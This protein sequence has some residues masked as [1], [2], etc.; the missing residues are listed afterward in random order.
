[1]IID[2]L[3]KE[4][5]DMALN[6]E[7]RI[8]FAVDYKVDTTSLQ[9]ARKSLQE[10]QK[11]SLETFNSIGNNRNAAN[12]ARQLSLLKQDALELEQALARSFNADLGV[13]NVQ[14]LR[15]ELSE[16]PM[17]EIGERFA[18]AGAA[19]QN[20]FNTIAGQALSLNNTLKQTGP[21]LTKIQQT[22]TNALS[23]NL[24]T[25][26]FNQITK[27]ISQAWGYSKNLDN[28]LNNIRI[29][30]RQSAEEMERFAQTAQ[31]TAKGLGQGTVDYT[32]AALIY[33]QQGLSDEEVAKKT[34]TTLKT[35]N[36]TGKSA[37][38]VSQL[39]T[40]VWN[41]YKVDAD[42]AE[43]YVDKLAAVASTTAADL[44]ELS[45]AMSKVASVAST[46][47]VDIDQLNAQISTI[48][49][50][51][52]QAP[53][54][55]GTALKTIYSRIGDLKVDGVDEF[56]V[57]LGKISSK[58]K[59]MGV[60][61]LDKNGDM[62]E[63][64]VVFEEVADKW[65]NWTSA[66]K[67]AA[68]VALGGS[69]QYTNLFALF[70]NW[71]DYESTLVTSSK[72]IGTLQE[73]Q[74]TYAERLTT[75]LQQ[76]R[77]AWEGVY[78]S[79]FDK[80]DA[81]KIVDKL[82]SI[83]ETIEKFFD[84]VGGGIPVIKLLGSMLL[85]TFSTKIASGFT[86][87]IE[88]S[89]ISLRNFTN[90]Q[91]R[92][93]RQVENMMRNLGVQNQNFSQYQITS[94]ADT[95]RMFRSR[96]SVMTEDELNRVNQS[97]ER[98]IQLE[99]QVNTHA[100]E[101]RKTRTFLQGLGMD[102][103][104]DYSL[105]QNLDLQRNQQTNQVYGQD[106]EKRQN[107]FNQIMS[108]RGSN[109]F[110]RVDL[111]FSR[112]FG[113]LQA[114]DQRMAQVVTDINQ[115][116]N[117]SFDSEDI[118]EIFQTQTR[119]GLQ[120][121]GQQLNTLGDN[122]QNINQRAQGAL[123][124]G[125]G[126]PEN[127][128]RG[129]VGQRD[130]GADAQVAHQQGEQYTQE[131]DILREAAR[132]QAPASAHSRA[133]ENLE[134]AQNQL[135]RLTTERA[136]AQ[137]LV[138]LYVEGARR[139]AQQTLETEL[140]ATADSARTRQ[141]N[142]LAEQVH[143]NTAVNTA[144][145]RV[146]V[147]RQDLSAAVATGDINAINQ[148]YTNLSNNQS[149][150][151]AA[152][153]ELTVAQQAYQRATQE[154]TEAVAAYNAAQQQD[155]TTLESHLAAM[156]SNS[157]AYREGRAEL[158]N[159]NAAMNHA[160]AEETAG[161]RAVSEE[162]DPAI[163]ATRSSITRLNTRM[164]ELRA[165]YEQLP[166]VM[167]RNIQGVSALDVALREQ[168]DAYQL[169]G[170]E[171]QGV[172][173]AYIQN[174]RDIAQNIEDQNVLQRKLVE[175]RQIFNQMRE[176]GLID[177]QAYDRVNTIYNHILD[178]NNQLKVSGET[179]R[180]DLHELTT[181]ETEELTRVQNS[182][183][184]AN[185][186][187][188]KQ[189]EQQ[190]DSARAE[191]QQITASQQ[192]LMRTLNM[193]EIIKSATQLATGI[194]SLASSA[195]MFK[196]AWTNI[197]SNDDLSTWEK[198]GQL[199]GSVGPMLI[200]M[201]PQIKNLGSI[202]AKGA[203]GL[204]QL[205]G[206]YRAATTAVEDNT[207]AMYRGN[208]TEE[209]RA[210]A[211]AKH[212]SLTGRQIT[213]QEAAIIATEQQSAA[214]KRYAEVSALAVNAALVFV[215][216]G[217]TALV[218]GL[219]VMHDAQEEAEESQKKFS[220]TVEEITKRNKELRETVEDNAKAFDEW[221]D[222]WESFKK[223]KVAVDD[224][225]TSMENLIEQLGLSDDLEYQRLLR[226]AEYTQDYSELEKKLNDIISKQKQV[227]SG[228]YDDDM[229][230]TL[231]IARQRLKTEVGESGNK[232]MQAWYSSNMS[233]E[234]VQAGINE[235]KELSELGGGI[236]EISEG[237]EENPFAYLTIKDWSNETIRF[238]S[239]HLDQLEAIK[240]KYPSLFS[241]LV[242]DLESSLSLSAGNVKLAEQ[243]FLQQAID[244]TLNNTDF[245][246]PE[247]TEKEQILNIE[248]QVQSTIQAIKDAYGKEIEDKDLEDI[249]LQVRNKF[250]KAIPDSKEILDKTDVLMNDVK[251]KINE[252]SES[253]KLA[254]SI[255]PDIGW[256]ISDADIAEI[257]EQLTGIGKDALKDIDWDSVISDTELFPEILAEVKEKGE[258]SDETLQA[259]AEHLTEAGQATRELTAD[260]DALGATWDDVN[261]KLEKN[262]LTDRNLRGNKEFQS[263]IDDDTIKQIR[264]FY[265]AASDVGKA[266]DI[267]TNEDISSSSQRWREAWEVYG[268]AIKN[269][270]IEQSLQNI[271]KEMDKLSPKKG[272]IQVQ[273]DAYNYYKVMDDILAEDYDIDVNIH[274][275]IDTELENIKSDLDDSVKL[276]T[277]IGEGFTL[278]AN[279]LNDFAD[280]MPEVLDE[281][282]VLSDGSIQLSQTAVESA[283]KAAI[284]K[285]NEE[286][287][288]EIQ[289]I[290]AQRAVVEHKKETVEEMLKIADK[291]AEGEYKT[292][293]A[294]K[295]AQTKLNEQ[296]LDL[297]KDDKVQAAIAEGK[298][299]KDQLTKLAS[300]YEAGLKQTAQ[301]VTQ[302]NEILKDF[303]LKETNY[304]ID[305]FAED[306][307]L[308]L[309]KTE[310]YRDGTGVIRER[311]AQESIDNQIELG[312]HLQE[313]LN[314]QKDDYQHM[315]D[316]YD[317]DIKVMEAYKK[318]YKSTWD[319]VGK[320]KDKKDTK[321]KS[322]DTK[323]KDKDAKDKQSKAEAKLIDLL[324]E[325][326]DAYH[327][328][329]VLIKEL[330]TNLSRLQK[331]QSKLYG[332]DLIE[333]LKQQGE[334]LD[335]QISNYE[336]KIRLSQME[337]S[338]TKQRLQA[339]GVQFND[340]GTVSNY[341]A[342]MQNKINYIRDL[343]IRYNAMSAE[344][345]ENFK[346]TLDEA[347]KAYN[348]FK[349]DMEKYDQL[350]TEDIPELED[351]IQDAIDSQIELK[352]SAFET[353]V[354]LKLDTT[355]AEKNMREFRR[356]VID[357]LQDDDILGN[358]LA[359]YADLAYYRNEQG[360]G[361][362]QIYTDQL[363]AINQAIAEIESTGWSERFGDN[364]N[365]AKEAQKEAQDNLRQALIDEQ[366]AIKNIKDAYLSMIDKA[367]EKWD[368]QIESYNKLSNLINH[369]M[370]IIKLLYGED[371]SYAML[372]QYYKK[373]NEYNQQQLDMYVKQA[374][375]WKAK[376]E[377][378]ADDP[379]LYKKL[380]E[381]WENAI[382]GGK[383]VLESSI[384]GIIDT[385][386]NAINEIFKELEDKLTNGLGFDELKNDWDFVNKESDRYLDSINGA[387]EIS[388]LEREMKD[389][390]KDTSDLA[391][392]QKLTASMNEQLDALKQKDKLTQYDLD[393]A[394]ALFDI[395]VKKAA[396]KDAQQNKS[397]MR[398]RRDAQGNYSYQFV[399]DEDS[400]AQA[401][402]ELAE[403]QNSLYNLDK[404]AYKSNLDEIYEVHQEYM[405]KVTDL[406]LDQSISNEEK[407]K[408]RAKLTE[409][410]N[411]VI[412]GLTQQHE[413]LKINL[414][415]STFQSLANMYGT[416]IDD[417]KNLG[418]PE[419]NELMQQTV[420]IWGSGIDQLADTLGK[421]GLYGT[422]QETF[423]K[424]RDKTQEYQEQLTQV[425]DLA[426]D[427][428]PDIAAGEDL[429]VSAME[430]MI[431]VNDV[432]INQ[433]ANMIDKMQAL[434]I[435]AIAFADGLSEISRNA[436]E[437]L[438]GS[439][440][441]D[442]YQKEKAQ[443]DAKTNAQKKVDGAM[444]NSQEAKQG[445]DYN[446]DDW[447][448]GNFPKI[449]DKVT[450][451]GDYYF[452]DSLGTA[453][454]GNRGEGQNKTVTVQNVAPNNPFPV[455]VMSNDSA[456]GWLKKYQ[457]AKMNT[458]GYTGNWNSKEGK[459]GIL[460]QKELVLN[461]YDTE[462]FLEAIKII[463]RMLAQNTLAEQI[464]EN[465][466]N[467]E[468][469]AEERVKQNAELI[470]IM[471]L[472]T[473]IGK[474]IEQIVN[475]N[476]NFPN[477]RDAEEI[478]AALEGL[479]NQMTQY[480]YSKSR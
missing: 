54:S 233:E 259:I 78:D 218:W 170:G 234:E 128:G 473:G 460:H 399:S 95:S 168:R 303:N 187:L 253:L 371:K 74:D 419:Q 373:Q 254:G 351:Q 388:K 30:T 455:A 295:K 475:V 462:N 224:V 151:T 8:S 215:A 341:S 14:R 221:E 161:S 61:I 301:Y 5:K 43:L 448:A 25:G 308:D 352:I 329:N 406:Y 279:E 123:V 317:T 206:A 59:T 249:E 335:Q 252:G 197:M 331:R 428:F 62:R 369:D 9:N 179:L 359:D 65:A 169:L 441:Y 302:R 361:V 93:Q 454:L 296:A 196:N 258:L 229:S 126:N 374:A 51:T 478:R 12:S 101:V 216:A 26:A 465:F 220:E 437:A 33:Y 191:L 396:F 116:S 358:A 73:Q 56:G 332:K 407:E 152:Q 458:G 236:F 144:Q 313:V 75:H 149:A 232:F 71:K 204:W 96:Q 175:Q 400:V 153:N 2:F 269:A 69:R 383:S 214:M 237:T 333:N 115:R 150:L 436:Y 79:A 64:G 124:S 242:E 188:Q 125:L 338:I 319:T 67:Q 450:Y 209:Q 208:F 286:I 28:S 349:E 467:K 310:S 272:E 479:T 255:D 318:N 410:Y 111:N 394:N 230:N 11:M 324:E 166:Q 100:E 439:R 471:K 181:A 323:D 420:S 409:D 284:E 162:Y 90:Q 39:L 247:G 293:D 97:M 355:E 52:R 459:I 275:R 434:A 401:A 470:S 340:D 53:E 314:A 380:K 243:G 363:S 171:V 325:E 250:L 392:Q 404:N 270:D 129:L 326:V 356:K 83:V 143:K 186:T 290:K 89:L 266:I 327:D 68:A 142:A 16:L 118:Q 22:L 58:L 451:L 42:E 364:I 176:Y 103:T 382:E 202:I 13:T 312:K 117:R 157:V 381:N 246:L 294:L 311:L 446:R 50:V 433:W 147:A 285:A 362:V 86:N 6:N 139:Q 274:G 85:S 55:V 177:D 438:E 148:A 390:I 464:K 20:A 199:L 264:T 248:K 207:A 105:Q 27:S 378:A 15:N 256:F 426:E 36:V 435:S 49:S 163:R 321:D 92:A 192:D 228:T 283:K 330:D 445:L 466:L 193:R 456:Y 37:A 386:T 91:E 104:D 164:N 398:L 316:S 278:S 235:L 47:G 476:A 40:A 268:E 357:Q 21:I 336:E 195:T 309:Y 350:L 113:N 263:L 395:E 226:I 106:F 457:I 452:Y 24:V 141:Q 132:I 34:E 31:K 145:S 102:F 307:G 287:D 184:Q 29:I 238:L 281:M 222:L 342:A 291:M 212:I 210:I 140:R 346:D 213:I 155:I 429:M 377:E 389:K 273:V 45:T 119:N 348:K 261:K 185:E 480:A 280:D 127:V 360:L 38:D 244:D 345:Q 277:K 63:M 421:E 134:T 402:Q 305:T 180:E 245:S 444:K 412:L 120:F 474:G 107:V 376:M 44:G 298:L 368:E 80:K 160:Q 339:E 4:E 76:L 112:E 334:L 300:Y 32:D 121:F 81:V 416:T 217:V 99:N 241:G 370:N 219:S 189:R 344:E 372:D 289:V 267:I 337:L 353:E 138:D 146:N 320:A 449:G 200:G 18:M 98:T 393:R 225:K 430:E 57:S 194:T 262:S 7:Q 41:G 122:L 408:Q 154:A 463:E 347:E 167:Q 182:F 60:D 1:M 48:I 19:G 343:Q 156:D 70:E 405:Q 174:S 322:K 379:E 461:A 472:Q 414:M 304:K 391:T 66:Q 239:D 198:M 299:Q 453:P 477:A 424:L 205:H 440:M 423:D 136:A 203:T 282:Q 110:G 223:G 77:T 403:A 257:S 422:M 87:F 413:Q 190:L 469:T 418:I 297:E 183:R 265:G 260:F 114:S 385:Y 201:V 23:W 375:L 3:Y 108:Q 387:Y 84:T 427:F 315:I 432:I 158:E 292:E 178:S 159:Y 415:G 443:E 276:V 133:T 135:N 35:A 354:Q 417:Y 137:D 227:A 10:L 131:Y 165:A 366:D 431:P 442:E 240:D 468:L 365:A 288:G 94:L 384:Q 17:R 88:N 306:L 328:I 172:S 82:T 46:T 251:T 411:N 109:A 425:T 211:Q 447:G 271:N 72:A 397:K 130:Y 173:D 367:Q 231:G